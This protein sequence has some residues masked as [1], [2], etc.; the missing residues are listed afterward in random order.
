MGKFSFLLLGLFFVLSSDFLIAQNQDNNDFD[1]LKAAY[2]NIKQENYD[3]AYPY[4]KKML[5]IY[6]K[7]PTYN[8]YVGRC[9]L[10]LDK[11]PENVIKYLRFAA[12]R[13]VASDVYFYLGIAYLK[14]YQFEDAIANF[15][16]FEKSANKKQLKDLDVKNHISMAQNGLYLI[17]YFKKPLI[18]S[19]ETASKIDFY[20]KY[21][22][23]D[24][25]GNFFDRYNY[26]NQKK[27]SLSENSILF[28]PDFLE[29]NEVLYFSAKNKKRGV[30]DIFR[31][32]R[33]NDTLWSEPENLG[34]K[35]NTPFD[36][37]YPFIHSDGT[38]LYFASKGHYSMG[39]YDLYRSSWSWNDQEWP[40]PENLDFP[41]NSP[42]DDI[43]FVPSHDKRTAYF[44]SDRELNESNYHVY[45][46]KF[47][48]SEP[49]I[50][51][52]THN[53][54]LEFAQLNVNIVPE[55]KDKIKINGDKFVKEQNNI[56]K[57]KVDDG[58][59]H[60]SEYDSLLN[61]AVNYQL[62]ADSLRWVIDD[63]RQVFDKTEK[64]QDRAILGNE[65]I[66]LEKNIYS[67]Q[68]N[69]DVCYERVRQIEQANLATKK[70]VYEKTENTEVEKKEEESKSRVSNQK[71]F[72]EPNDNTFIK[73]KLESQKVKEEPKVE[74]T[75]YGLRV[76]L[77]STYNSKNPILV[78]EKLPEG[79]IYMIQL[80]AYSSIKKPEVFK[81][82]EPLT[83]IKKESSGIRKYFAGRFFQIAD[84]EKNLPL[85]R[86]KGFKDAYIV[87]FNNGNIIPVKNAVKMESEVA[88]L[89]K[90]EILENSIE[91]EKKTEEL[92]ITYILKGEIN[93]NDTT[94]I[95]Q[96]KNVLPDGKDFYFESEKALNVFIVKSFSTFDEAYPIKKELEA[97]IK[98]EIE[99]HA[100]FA[101]SQIPLDQ[102]RKIT[103]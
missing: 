81:G 1:D 59:L 56:V 82:L 3:A 58:F 51:Y 11:E 39:G 55:K 8:Y 40:E 98:K 5:D 19:K 28:V 46:I 94:L 95:E 45:K 54:I 60:K 73:S 100:Y 97:I 91:E 76:K 29:R 32:T 68:K 47:E 80:G 10:F 63:Q 52:Q 18:Y 38:T 37:N 6:L 71:V 42:F 57:I 101:E 27:D 2:L 103:K 74:M 13:D 12:T 20:K 14:T 64:G 17:K 83:C 72:V 92:S 87:A 89:S 78:N 93:S 7:D 99:I 30:Y 86:S 36:E 23:S 50:Q 43:L 9:L 15:R 21:Q 85:V 67:L 31:S 88:A 25:D 62:R 53:Q 49:Y 35:I 69:A 66:E 24:L 41:I 4:F 34:E 44:S 33:L 48:N 65:I 75:N 22:F 96:A 90:T 102:A 79:I 70:T 26:F 77:P 61:L 16:W 84:A